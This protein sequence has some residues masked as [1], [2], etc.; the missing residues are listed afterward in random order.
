MRRTLSRS[1]QYVLAV[2]VSLGTAAALVFAPRLAI[3]AFGAAMLVVVAFVA[4]VA[5]LVLILVITGVV[6][7]STQN[8]LAGDAPIILSDLLLLAG[9]LRTALVI[10][11][12][13]LTVAQRRK[14]LVVGA[15][16]VVVVLQ[17]VRGMV[18]GHERGT[19]GFEFRTLLAFAT[20]VIALP[21]LTNRRQWERLLLGL[22]V[23]GFILGTWGLAQ[24]MLGLSF[25]AGYG[26]REGVSGAPSGRGQLQ[27][28][29]YGFPVAVVIAFAVLNSGAVTSRRGRTALLAVFM[30][31]SVSLLLTY[32][33]TFWIATV[34]AMGFVVWRAGERSRVRVLT[35]SPAILL[36]LIALLLTPW[37]D[38]VVAG[39]ERLV[40]LG[41]YRNDN[42]VRY[43]I[44]ES[45]HVFDE[46]KSHPI[47][48]EGL[49]ATVVWARP[50]D[51]VPAR[52]YH[53]SHNAY[54]WLAWKIGVPAAAMLCVVIVG[55]IVRARPVSGSRLFAS[56]LTGAQGALLLLMLANLAFP[57][58]NTY[59]ITAVM[60]LVLALC[61][62]SVEPG[63]V[64]PNLNAPRGTLHVST[65]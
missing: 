16:L 2:L 46:I 17:F 38:A 11:R 36:A 43:R 32:E 35:R 1:N 52:H 41:D 39:R 14:L 49:G 19:T 37:P 4:P 3:G 30:L 9:L 44:A 40:T 62:L 64:A 59:G 5:N 15:F 6:P 12:T 51:Q 27:G 10:G 24:W 28:G 54:L 60:G 58:F 42:S 34:A 61:T 57:S 8:Q 47:Q 33:R 21:V 18:G 53:Y 31:N 63:D 13:P 48:G 23:A 45:T 29:L 50:W 25:E 56:I 26:V 20:F 55:A 22:L 7:F 65:P